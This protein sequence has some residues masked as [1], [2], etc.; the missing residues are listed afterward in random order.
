[1]IEKTEVKEKTLKEK[2]DQ[3]ALKEIADKLQDCL[4]FSLGMVE[5]FII[6]CAKKELEDGEDEK[7]D[8]SYCTLRVFF[9]GAKEKLESYLDTTAELDSIASGLGLI[10]E[11]AS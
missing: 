5:T 3:K 10:E 7:D 9:E 1:M 11:K 4:Y 8:T 6:I 2:A